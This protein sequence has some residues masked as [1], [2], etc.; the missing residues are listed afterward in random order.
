MSLSD[1]F[2]GISRLTTVIEESFVGFFWHTFHVSHVIFGEFK[3]VV[4]WLGDEILSIYGVSP[5]DKDALIHQTTWICLCKV[6]FIGVKSP[7]E[8]PI[9]YK[10]ICRGEVKHHI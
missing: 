1:L 3:V 9:S 7:Q 6:I 10:A 2:T 5:R 8:H 4:I